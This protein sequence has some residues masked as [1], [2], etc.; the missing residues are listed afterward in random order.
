MKNII[1]VVDRVYYQKSEFNPLNI[2]NSFDRQVSSDE[3]LFIRNTK[4]SL[5]WKRLDLGWVETPGMLL[6]TNDSPQNS[7]G[8][9]QLGISVP[10]T[11]IILLAKILPKEHIRYQPA[12][13]TIQG[14]MIRSQEQDSKYTIIAI[15]G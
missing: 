9:L 3:Q 13:E 14:L 15:P 7:A 8:I 5:E 1:T 10:N 4:A 12:I 2:V 6:I 11:G